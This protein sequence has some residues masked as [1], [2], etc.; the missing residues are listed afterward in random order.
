M[1]ESRKGS[2]NVTGIG[3]VL[4]DEKIWKALIDFHKSTIGINGI[5]GEK[6]VAWLYRQRPTMEWETFPVWL[7]AHC[8]Y[9]ASHLKPLSGE[10]LEKLTQ[11][12]S[13]QA[14][15]NCCEDIENRIDL[16]KRYTS[17][18]RTLLNWLKRNP[19]KPTE[20]QQTKPCESQQQ[21]SETP[22]CRQPNNLEQEALR[23][24]VQM[25]VVKTPANPSRFNEFKTLVSGLAVHHVDMA[26]GKLCLCVIINDKQEHI[27]EFMINYY[28]SWQDFLLIVS[29][30]FRIEYVTFDF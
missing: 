25:L 20:A 10:E 23:R 7:S 18:Y 16:R 2:S 22:S 29:Q 6:I 11:Q 4:E 21:T 9:I 3:A 5:T 26:S 17:L 15:R 13:E 24:L 27:T 28:D 8:P 30:C 14:I 19:P 12:Y 1:K